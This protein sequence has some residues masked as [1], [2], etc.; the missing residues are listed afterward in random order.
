MQEAEGW[1]QEA[2]S[3][4]ECYNC[5]R[6]PAVRTCT[7]VFGSQLYQE[8]TM[9]AER[10][11]E[12]TLKGNPITL[13]G[14]KIGAN[15]EAPDFTVQK[16]LLTPI[17]LSETHGKV[18]VIL[19]VPSLDTPVCSRQAKRFSDEA[20]NLGDDVQVLVVSVDTPFAQGRW[21]GAEGVQNILTLSD[22]KTRDF[23]KKYGVEIKGLG[24][25]TRAAFV[26]DRQGEVL[27]SEY[28]PEVAEEPNYDAILEAAKAAV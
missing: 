4:L 14:P 13:L 23:G 27:Y 24:I 18:R 1:R 7:G 19:S 25:Y 17:S 22:F 10:Q 8:T 5:G 12:V 2:E 16:D 9:A 28:V 26:L 3:A 20:A 21:C 11:G 6:L 15:E